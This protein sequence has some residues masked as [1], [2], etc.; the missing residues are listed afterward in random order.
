M[1]TLRF[2]GPLNRE[3]GGYRLRPRSIA[4]HMR[5][6]R[7]E[8]GRKGPLRRSTDPGGCRRGSRTLGRALSERAPAASACE[9]IVSWCRGVGL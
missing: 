7:P 3:E 2:G 5:R 8:L 6:V 9:P 4:Y 1:F